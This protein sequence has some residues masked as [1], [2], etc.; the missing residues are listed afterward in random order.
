MAYDYKTILCEIDPPIGRI[1]INQPEK[2]NPLSY[3][4]L[5]EIAEAEGLAFVAHGA[6]VD[7][8]KDFRPG[9]QAAE[10]AGAVAPFFESQLNKNEIRFLSKEMGLPSWNRPSMACLA[11]RIPYGSP[12]TQ[13]KLKMVK[14]AEMVLFDL[15]FQEVRVRH[16]GST[17]RIETAP[18]E[19]VKMMAEDF[20]ATVVAKLREIGFLHIALD[21]EGYATGKLNRELGGNAHE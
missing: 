10:E 9:T 2:R 17:A 16:H 14:A 7:D 11:S 6:N 4:R 15:G 5:C 20:R 19:M 21:L 12:I 8:L 3:P 18:D 13:Q 1:V